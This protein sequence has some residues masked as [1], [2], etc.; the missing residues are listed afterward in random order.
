MGGSVV[1][2]VAVIIVAAV[3]VSSAKEP[4]A[5]SAALPSPST[6]AASLSR[7]HRDKTRSEGGIH[8]RQSELFVQKFDWLWQLN[9]DS[10]NA[11]SRYYHLCHGLN[12]IYLVSAEV[13]SCHCGKSNTKAKWNPCSQIKLFFWWANSRLTPPH[14][15]EM[16]ERMQNQIKAISNICKHC[17]DTVYQS[18]KVAIQPGIYRDGEAFGERGDGFSLLSSSWKSGGRGGGRGEEG[19][20]RVVFQGVWIAGRSRRR[21]QS[22]LGGFPTLETNTLNVCLVSMCFVYLWEM[23]TVLYTH[24]TLLV[25]PRHQTLKTQSVT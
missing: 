17:L 16:N 24:Y 15:R 7:L 25:R 5:Q 23:V 19:G 2:S 3:V 18:A 21:N 6:A 20:S 14:Q 1:G 13:Y 8:K 4:L 12:H 9:H 11:L 10:S 22:Q